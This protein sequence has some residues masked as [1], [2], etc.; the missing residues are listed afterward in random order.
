MLPPAGIPRHSQEKCADL[1][2]SIY[3]LKQISR[4]WNKE[5]RKFLKTLHFQQSKQDYSL[6]T[7]TNEGEFLVILVYVDDMLVTGTS[8][9]QIEEVK[10]ALYK[11]FT[12]KDLGQ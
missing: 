3:G 5:L 1:K 4:Q 7:R 10:V 11:T 6:F 12:I 9:S 8:L 2:R